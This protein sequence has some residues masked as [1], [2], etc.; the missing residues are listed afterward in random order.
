V[1]AQNLLKTKQGELG[2]DLESLTCKIRIVP[3][4]PFG[5]LNW[6]IISKSEF[7]LSILTLV[8]TQK[9]S[10]CQS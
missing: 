4:L 7:R 1:K 10:D 3:L 5:I 8:N 6:I 9:L 2:F